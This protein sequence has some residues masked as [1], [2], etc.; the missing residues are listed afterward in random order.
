MKPLESAEEF[1][2]RL[3]DDCVQDGNGNWNSV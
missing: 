3:L 2:E 1:A